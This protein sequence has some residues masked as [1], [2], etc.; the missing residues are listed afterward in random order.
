MGQDETGWDE[1]GWDGEPHPSGKAA[2]GDAPWGDDAWMWIL[3]QGLVLSWGRH[4]PP[5]S[6]IP[7]S[8]RPSPGQAGSLAG[9]HSGTAREG[10]WLGRERTGGGKTGTNQ[11]LLRWAAAAWAVQG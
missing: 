3:G 5:S 2:A 10:V 4:F 7:C 6:C 1:V 11:P 9:D 8:I